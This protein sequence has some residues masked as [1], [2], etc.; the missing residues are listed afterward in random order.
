VSKSSEGWRN[1]AANHG[2]S[3]S[4]YVLGGNVVHVDFPKS[5]HRHGERTLCVRS[6]HWNNAGMARF[7]RLS[8][9]LFDL[10]I[11]ATA[12]RTASRWNAKSAANSFGGSLE[13][14]NCCHI[15]CDCSHRVWH[16]PLAGWSDS[17]P[18]CILHSHACPLWRA[19][20]CCE[21]GECDGQGPAYMVSSLCRHAIRNR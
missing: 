13:A 19:E 21:S 9:L 15:S 12:G 11:V 5:V 2:H 14:K 20:C 1:Q 17:L 18:G 8:C 3:P 6:L 16:T 7:R 10:G 4:L